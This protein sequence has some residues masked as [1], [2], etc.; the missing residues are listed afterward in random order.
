MG[1]DESEDWTEGSK[2]VIIGEVIESPKTAKGRATRDRIVAAASDLIGERGVAETSIDDVIERAGASK[3]QLYHYFEDRGAL[4]RA[5]V[6]HNT[7]SVLGGLGR[8]DGWNAIRSW[9]DSMVAVQVERHARGGCRL[10]SLVAQLAEADE[11]ARLALAASFARWEAYV[12]DGLRSMQAQGK[13][14]RRADPDELA[15]ATMAAIQGGLLLTQTRRDPDQLAIALDAAYTH[16]R[17]HA[18]AA[19]RAA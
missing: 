17:A 3:S 8:L 12:R 14:A 10:G 7:D 1:E 16:L 18:A 11:E 5:V 2:F 13:L 6:V 9:F 15:T 4:L 19:R